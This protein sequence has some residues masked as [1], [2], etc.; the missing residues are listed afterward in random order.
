[1]AFTLISGA[2]HSLHPA[3]TG[4][5]SNDAAGFA[6][7]YGPPSRSPLRAF[8]TGLRPH[9][10]PRTAAS[11]LPGLLTA[12]RTGL[13]PASDD[14]LT[15]RNHLHKA[16]SDLL[17][18]RKGE[19]NGREN[20]SPE[21]TGQPTV[22]SA[23]MSKSRRTAAKRAAGSSSLRPAAAQIDQL[24]AAT[25]AKSS[26]FNAAA[27]TC[28][29]E[30]LSEQMYRRYRA[31]LPPDHLMMEHRAPAQQAASSAELCS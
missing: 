31:S 12:T 25:R 8:D 22:Y 18:A 19:V 15:T 30:T 2:R 6:S 9:G 29:L 16:T 28:N 27:V 5:T 17:V 1:M 11:L 23:A 4:G 20:R 13:T 3:T 26:L 24:H 10:F 14:E 7:C 21:N